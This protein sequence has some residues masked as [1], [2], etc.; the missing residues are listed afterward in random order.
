MSVIDIDLDLG[1]ITED[2]EDSSLKLPRG[3]MSNSQVQTYYQC[4]YKY[5][6]SYCE[7]APRKSSVATS[8]GKSVHRL[9][10]DTLRDVMEGKPLRSMEQAMD[11]ASGIVSAELSDLESL[12]DPDTGAERDEGH[13]V[14]E[15][16]K[17]YRVWHQMRAKNVEPVAVEKRFRTIVKGVPVTGVI[18][19]IDISEGP[20]IV[21]LKVT[22]T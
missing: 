14:D 4:G 6:L 20:T 8:L 16:R 12:A 21:D 9:V 17:Y 3:Y 18:D 13:W 15:A 5:Y 10:E 7:D 1:E 19:L 2:E 22:K 11:E